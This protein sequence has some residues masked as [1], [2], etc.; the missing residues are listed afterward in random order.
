MTNQHYCTKKEQILNF[1]L[2]FITIQIDVTTKE[3]KAHSEPFYVLQGKETQ[4]MTTLQWLLQQT[5]CI[6][7]L[8]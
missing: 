1:Q 7:R 3:V 8:I 5:Q 6:A 4:E 2:A